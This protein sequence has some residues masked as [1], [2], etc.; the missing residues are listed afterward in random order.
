MTRIGEVV[1]GRRIMIRMTASNFSTHRLFV[2]PLIV[3][4]LSSCLQEQP[5]GLQAQPN[6]LQAGGIEGTGGTGNSP[7][8]PCGGLAGGPQSIAVDPTGQFAYVAKAD[9]TLAYDGQVS[10]YAVNATTGTLTSIGSPVPTQDEGAISV[11]V[12]PTGKFAYVANWGGGDTAGSLST[13]NINAMTGTLTSTATIQAPCAPPPSPGSCAPWSVAVDPSG[14]FA[15]V[16]NEGGFAPTSVSMYVINA[17]SGALTF[18]GV[19]TVASG[20]RASSVTAN[21]KGTLVYVT[22]TTDFPA[23]SA[24]EVSTYAVNANTGALTF[25]GSIASGIDPVS[26]A[27]DPAGKFVYVTNRDSNDVS[28]YTIDAT[29]G[30]LTSTGTLAAG[31]NPASVA[32]DPT[33][34]FV[35]VANTGSNNVSMYT[36][37]GATGALT[38]AGTLA[39]E[40]APTSIAIHPSGKVAYVTNSGSNSVSVYSIDAGTGALT[41]VATTGT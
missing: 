15:Y 5:G 37:N 14:K 19:V 34:K 17:T 9:C 12:D 41:L 1:V 6:G 27:V 8:N 21:P 22:A 30:S 25:V 11:A 20:G 13:Y 2:L 31:T 28:M 39:T 32:V 26:T 23:S 40:L 7:A 35:Y 29:A 10:M 24:G 38:P 4:L 33:G 36:I 18:I 3:L 16:A